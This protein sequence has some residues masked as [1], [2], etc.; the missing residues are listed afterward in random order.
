MMSVGLKHLYISTRSFSVALTSSFLKIPR[1]GSA[2]TM[3]LTH[4][5]RHLPH[6]GFT[7]VMRAVTISPADGTQVCSFPLLTS[8]RKR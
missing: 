8:T 4:K 5:I 7:C 2:K 1:N 3:S 6:L